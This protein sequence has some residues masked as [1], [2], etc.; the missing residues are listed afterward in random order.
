MKAIHT[1]HEIDG[2]TFFEYLTEDVSN[3]DGSLEEL[4]DN[5]SGSDSGNWLVSTLSYRSRS[6]H[7]LEM[8]RRDDLPTSYRPYREKLQ[9]MFEAAESDL[10][11][12]LQDHSSSISQQFL[13][14]GNLWEYVV[15]LEN[16]LKSLRRAFQDRLL[17]QEETDPVDDSLRDSVSGF[18]MSFAEVYRAAN[19]AP[20]LLAGQTA[21]QSWRAYFSELDHRFQDWFGY[22][23]P[24]GDF[25]SQLH[26][27]E[28]HQNFWWLSRKPVLSEI[29]GPE[30]D[31]A[32]LLD[33]GRSGIM[34]SGKVCPE[35][36][37]VIAYAFHELSG[38]E[39]L[40]MQ[41]HVRS[42]S[43]CLNQVLDIR[44]AQQEAQEEE[45]KPVEWA[46][47]L[48]EI[49]K[50]HERKSNNFWWDIPTETILQDLSRRFGNIIDWPQSIPATLK[51][52]LELLFMAPFKAEA[53]PL[54]AADHSGDVVIAK[55]VTLDENGTIRDIVPVTVIV[56]HLIATEEG[57]DISG[58][59]PSELEE[60]ASIDFRFGWEYPDRT[61]L[62]FEISRLERA[63]V[64][65]LA[66]LKTS[67]DRQDGNVLIL[68]IR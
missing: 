21:F 4:E 30:L 22:L 16:R 7:A 25:L 6:F 45:R 24:V 57:I 10:N 11:R 23:E 58:E 60:I 2:E 46:T 35:S 54:M 55:L 43:I 18:L 17:F 28:Y 27:R 9:S 51:D 67:Y 34:S 15:H 52:S 62:L 44:A 13:P 42:C 5:L 50:S 64:Y 36:E 20:V 49:S 38:Q 12:L 47:Y 14:D 19:D 26:E 56:H 37:R 39:R 40:E 32:W 29:Q 61:F 3:F 63:G 59:L 68:L 31:D 1:I 41:K 33:I 65:F 53:L 8:L 66:S 48:S